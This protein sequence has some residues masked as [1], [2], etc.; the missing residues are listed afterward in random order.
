M[1]LS[2]NLYNYLVAKVMQMGRIG[3]VRHS[4]DFCYSNTMVTVHMNIIFIYAATIEF[5]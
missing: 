2:C 3:K 5:P 1:H 4:L